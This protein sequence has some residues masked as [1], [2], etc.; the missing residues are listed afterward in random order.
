MTLES[1]FFLNINFRFFQTNNFLSQLILCILSIK[2]DDSS[3]CSVMHSFYVRNQER[4]K[5]ALINGRI[6]SEAG[7]IYTNPQV[8]Q[9]ISNLP[10]IY[11]FYTYKFRKKLR[12]KISMLKDLLGE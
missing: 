11:N 4:K 12:N 10:F 6:D 3:L 7:R 9:F 5:N 8:H 2:H 1:F